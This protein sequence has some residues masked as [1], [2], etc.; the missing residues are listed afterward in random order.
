VNTA[1]TASLLTLS[2]T[3]TAQE[4]LMDM[5]HVALLGLLHTMKMV[6]FIT[7][8]HGITNLIRVMNILATS[9]SHITR[10]RVTNPLLTVDRYWSVL[11]SSKSET[12]ITMEKKLC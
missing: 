7:V 2:N 12:V 3:M 10:M 11:M 6:L 5:S 4:M 1:T 8:K 9:A